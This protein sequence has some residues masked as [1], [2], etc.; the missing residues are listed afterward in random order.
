[1]SPPGSSGAP[2]IQRYLVWAKAYI[3]YIER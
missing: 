2:P 3:A 1:L